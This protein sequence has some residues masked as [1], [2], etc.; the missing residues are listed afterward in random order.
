ML[1]HIVDVSAQLKYELFS[2]EGG[3]S[4]QFFYM[5]TTQKIRLGYVRLDECFSTFF[6]VRLG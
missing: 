2:A 3:K 5:V 6:K 1:P 4:G